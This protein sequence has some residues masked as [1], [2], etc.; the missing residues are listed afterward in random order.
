MIDW[1]QIWNTFRSGIAIGFLVAVGLIVLFVVYYGFIA[2][3]GK[4]RLARA[5]TRAHQIVEAGEVPDERTFN[6]VYYIL[7][8]VPNDPD[9]RGL[10]AQ[11]DKLK[12]DGKIEK[13]A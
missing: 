4:A 7:S 9:A 12:A 2:S 10:L 6:Y 8:R 3:T 13:A 1:G 5:K 11:L